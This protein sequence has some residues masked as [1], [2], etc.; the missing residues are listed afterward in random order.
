MQQ[1][2]GWIEISKPNHPKLVNPGTKPSYHSATVGHH[3]DRPF[4]DPFF[5]IAGIPAEI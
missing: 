1:I 4:A 2:A 3:T 5:S